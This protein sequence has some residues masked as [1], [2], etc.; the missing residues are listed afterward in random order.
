[1]TNLWEFLCILEWT[2][3]ILEGGREGMV[4]VACRLLYSIFRLGRGLLYFIG[5]SY[6][7]FYNNYFLRAR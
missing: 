4:R 5:S 6:G 7:S 2:Y 1:M 3:C